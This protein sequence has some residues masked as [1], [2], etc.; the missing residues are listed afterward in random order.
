MATRTPSHP[1]GL[2][3][4]TYI[5]PLNLTVTEVA[6]ALEVS[7]ATLSRLLNE[8]IDLSPEMAVKLSKVLGRTPAGWMNLQ[9]NHTLAK[10]AT[11]PAIKKWNPSK[12]LS[13]DGLLVKGNS[14]RKSAVRKASGKKAAA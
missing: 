13:P 3:K 9:A 12:F 6:G 2:I 11:D 10:L 5:E 14:R 8:K 7:P 4:R 1:G